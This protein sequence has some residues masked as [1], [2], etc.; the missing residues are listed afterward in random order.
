LGVAAT[1]HRR[2]ASP[3][4]SAATRRLQEIHTPLPGEPRAAAGK[5]RT[6][7]RTTCRRRAPRAAARSTSAEDEP[8][9]VVDAVESSGRWCCVHEAGGEL[10]EGA[11]TVNSLGET[12]TAGGNEVARGVRVRDP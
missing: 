3:L 4:G 11:A 10:R 5:R 7:R 8:G 1:R 12:M 9:E 2:H 6:R